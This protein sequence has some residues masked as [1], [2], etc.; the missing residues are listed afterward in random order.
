MAAGDLTTLADVKAYLGMTGEAVDDDLLTRLITAASTW[1]KTQAAHQILSATYTDTFDGSGGTRK[2]L[3]NFPVISVTSVTVDGVAIPARPAIG[4]D[5][6]VLND[7]QVD[8]FGFAFTTGVV[9]CAIVYVA[10]YATAPVDVAQAVI[11]LV[12]WR[13]REK[14]RIGQ[15]SR[16]TSQGEVVTFQRDAA[17]PSTEAVIEQYRGAH[18]A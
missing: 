8:L 1:F 14:D 2:V 10:G 9:N 4:Q 13:Y 7:G 16:T 12:A 11:E 17:P 15:A 18:V 5:G 6:Y 3:E